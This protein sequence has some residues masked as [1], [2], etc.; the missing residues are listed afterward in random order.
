MKIFLTVLL[1]MIALSFNLTVQASTN[2]T[3][4]TSVQQLSQQLICEKEKEKKAEEEPQPE[5]EEP[6][7]D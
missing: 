1:T 5:D 6:E 4:Y 7:C 3:S 2:T